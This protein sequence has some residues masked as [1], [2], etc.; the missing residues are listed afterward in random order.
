MLLLSLTGNAQS[1][2]E[3]NH[4]SSSTSAHLNLIEEGENNFTRLFMSN[5]QVDRDFKLNARF[6]T[7]GVQDDNFRLNYYNGSTTEDIIAI[8]TL[9]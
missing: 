1:H 2:T 5:A 7:E 6:N 9:M 4:S 8:W 3:I